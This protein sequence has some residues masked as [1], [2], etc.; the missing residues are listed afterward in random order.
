[1]SGTRRSAAAGIGLGASLVAVVVAG[2]VGGLLGVVTGIGLTGAVAP[3]AAKP[4]DLTAVQNP[5]YDTP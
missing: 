5:T 1:M 3:E 4:I 2:I